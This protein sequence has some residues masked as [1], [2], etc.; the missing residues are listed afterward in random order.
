MRPTSIP[1]NTFNKN[2]I[3]QINWIQD[4]VLLVKKK[5]CKKK[6]VKQETGVHNG[7]SWYTYGCVY[8]LC[9][10][11]SLFRSSLSLLI[12]AYS[13]PYFVLI[14]FLSER[15]L[16]AQLQRQFSF[17]MYECVI[18]HRWRAAAGKEMPQKAP[19]HYSRQQ[20]ARKTKLITTE[21][22]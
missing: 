22:C 17:L 18:T 14:I 11:M 15:T 4:E 7:W 9:V 13:R 20:K 2:F 6:N 8:T 10:C 3:P 21:I 5:K 19:L 1:C 16:T 12:F